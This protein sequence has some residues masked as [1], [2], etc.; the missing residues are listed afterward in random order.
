[1]SVTPD[2][3]RRLLER[4]DQAV[5]ID[6]ESRTIALED[7]ASEVFPIEPFARYCLLQG[8]DQLSFLL[9]QEEAITAYERRGGP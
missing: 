1:M 5:R 4:P 7:G 6:L 2:L 8:L 3:H 9:S